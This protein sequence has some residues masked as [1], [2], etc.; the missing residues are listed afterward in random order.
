M[1]RIFT[2]TLGLQG[3]ADMSSFLSPKKSI[4]SKS[5]TV[6]MKHELKNLDLFH[7]FVV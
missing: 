4:C 7:D 5:C 6:L 3:S 1:K 2:L